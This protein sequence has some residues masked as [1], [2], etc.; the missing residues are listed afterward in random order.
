MICILKSM[1]AFNNTYI[2]RSCDLSNYLFSKRLK[3]C[4]SGCKKGQACE[5]GRDGF[6]T[7]M[8]W[9]HFVLWEE[10]EMCQPSLHTVSNWKC[11]AKV[12]INSF[13]W[14]LS[15]LLCHTCIDMHPWVCWCMHTITQTQTHKHGCCS[16]NLLGYRADVTAHH[17]HWSRPAPQ[18]TGRAQPSGPV[19][20][21]ETHRWVRQT[22]RRKERP[23]CTLIL[24]FRLW[25]VDRRALLLIQKTLGA[26]RG[27]GVQVLLVRTRLLHLWQPARQILSTEKQMTMTSKEWETGGGPYIII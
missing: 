11:C 6:I 25:A 20:W 1:H 2:K 14:S 4:G 22:G 13:G 3:W 24:T 7:R 10:V 26:Q 12:S 17:H 21:S 16:S 27:F 8:F 9:L 15:M 19:V 5:L 18:K 23:D